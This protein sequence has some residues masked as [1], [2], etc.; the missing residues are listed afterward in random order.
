MVVIR[1]IMLTWKFSLFETISAKFFTLVNTFTD[2]IIINVI[3]NKVIFCEINL[4]PDVIYLTIRAQ[5]HNAFDAQLI[6]G[7]TNGPS[8]GDR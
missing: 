8:K 2:N 6:C 1:M 7:L 3:V 5:E 4:M